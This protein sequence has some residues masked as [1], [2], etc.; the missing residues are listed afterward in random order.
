VDHGVKTYASFNNHYAGF[1]PVDPRVLAVMRPFLEAGIGN[2]SA[3]HSLGAEARESLEAARAKA[4]Q[5]DTLMNIAVVDAG[6]NLKAFARMEGAFL[7]SVDIS[8]KKA[9]TAGMGEDDQKM[10]SE[11][12]QDLTDKA[13]AQVDKALESKQ[14]EIMQV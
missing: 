4:K 13:I 10:W 6:G 1:A 9:K 14:Q 3:R 11:E 12:V 8:I 5:Q 2:P 7:G